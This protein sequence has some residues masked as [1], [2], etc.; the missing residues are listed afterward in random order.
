MMRE[1]GSRGRASRENFAKT[2]QEFFFSS[3]DLIILA[4]TDILHFINFILNNSVF[5]RILLL[6]GDTHEIPKNV[7]LRFF[8][9]KKFFRSSFDSK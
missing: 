4:D 2:S 1:V 8:R 5:S 9:K 6:F 3:F 7:G